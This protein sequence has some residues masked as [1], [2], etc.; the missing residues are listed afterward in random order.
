[1]TIDLETI[2][3]EEL[4]DLMQEEQGFTILNSEQ[5]HRR[6]SSFYMTKLVQHNESGRVFQLSYIWDDNY[7]EDSSFEV[8]E[9]SVEKKEQTII[10]YT[11]T[12]N[13]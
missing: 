1:M 3:K 9:G 13:K 10:T 2:D 8:V 12:P 7:G 4:K 5:E 6:G 11:F